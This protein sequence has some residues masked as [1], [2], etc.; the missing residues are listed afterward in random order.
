MEP[1]TQSE[2]SPPDHA[3]ALPLDEIVSAVRRVRHGYV[4]I[5]V[6]DHKVIQIDVH[7]KRRLDHR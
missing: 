3:E 5:V 6:Q 1:K 7:E 2:K 4:Q